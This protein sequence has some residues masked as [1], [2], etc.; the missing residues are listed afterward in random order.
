MP[1]NYGTNIFTPDSCPIFQWFLWLTCSDEYVVTGCH[2]EAIPLVVHTWKLVAVKRIEGTVHPTLVL[3]LFHDRWAVGKN[4]T[5][6]TD[7]GE[8]I[9]HA[10]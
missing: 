2:C 4:M 1:Q 7:E 9:Q 8:I 6:M 5:M 3:F 10:E